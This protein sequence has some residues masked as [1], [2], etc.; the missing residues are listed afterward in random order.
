MIQAA[1]GLAVAHD[2][3]IVHRDI[4]P[5]N[6]MIDD[7]GV[8]KV[9]DLGLARLTADHSDDGDGITLS[10][11]L[12][13]TVDYMSP[14]QA[15]DPPWPTPDPT[16]TAWAA[17]CT[18]CSPRPSH[19]A[20][21]AS[22]NACLPI[23]KGPYRAYATV[24]PT[25]RPPSTNCSATWLRRTRKIAQG[26]WPSSSTASRRVMLRQRHPPREIPAAHGL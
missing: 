8:V 2:A 18:S 9:L 21:P 6:L 25:C 17:P 22:C 11:S 3:G 16:F 20:R 15:F 26:R 1:R 14:E 7:A 24:A 5:S 10:G 12:M 23:A 4:K 13:G 19:T